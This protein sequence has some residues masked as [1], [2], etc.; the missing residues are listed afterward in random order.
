MTYSLAN[1]Y[2]FKNIDQQKLDNFRC[3]MEKKAHQLNSLGLVILAKEG[4]NTTLAGE[5]DNLQALITWTFK[6]LDIPDSVNVRWSQCD[7][8]PFKKFNIKVRSEI[9][10]FDREGLFPLPQRKNHLSPQQW[11][12]MMKA[13]NTKVI[14]TRNS[15]ETKI[16]KFKGA[17]D[18]N[19][20]EFTEL[21]EK[22]QQQKDLNPDTNYLIYCTGGIRCE[23]AIYALE[24]MGLKNTYQL[25]GGILNYLES[26][27]SGNFEG[28]CFVFDSRVSVDNN[29]QASKKYSLCPHCGDVADTPVD[30]RKCDTPTLVCG[31]CLSK[32]Y[33]PAK[34]PLPW[35]FLWIN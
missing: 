30:C 16:G 19:I 23:K 26:E 21:P 5:K 25:D 7:S 3:D 29:L 33:G 10:T 12:E 24:E 35:P 28:E 15:Y 27:N 31:T 22:L 1:F 2:F 14:D 20:D 9:V 8:P 11:D 32:E 34:A 18:L 6:Q 13:P 4:I 17:L